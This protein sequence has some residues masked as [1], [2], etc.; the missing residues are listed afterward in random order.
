M[1]G[2]TLE[3]HAAVNIFDDANL[4]L[5]CAPE[6]LSAAGAKLRKTA[7]T[8]AVVPR[9]IFMSTSQTRYLAG[10]LGVPSR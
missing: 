2:P 4:S 5:A 7:A 9:E 3:V 10:E 8:A 6:L 1:P